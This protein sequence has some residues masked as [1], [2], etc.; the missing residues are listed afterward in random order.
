MIS[1]NFSLNIEKESIFLKIIFM[2]L[3]NIKKNTING[4][5]NQFKLRYYII[6]VNK[7]VGYSS[8]K[9]F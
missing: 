8:D 4:L 1:Y 9:L 7:M 2:T 3:L 6:L 5:L